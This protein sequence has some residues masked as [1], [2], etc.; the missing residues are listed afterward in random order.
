MYMIDIKFIDRKYVEKDVLCL[1]MSVG[2]RKKEKEKRSYLLW[3]SGRALDPRIWRYKVQFNMG[4][5]N[6]FSLSHACDKTKNIFLYFFSELKPYHL[7]C[8]V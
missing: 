6:F 3:L 8:S 5:Q 7:S 2:Q 4:T 1:F